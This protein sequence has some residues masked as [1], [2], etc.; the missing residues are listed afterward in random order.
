MKARHLVDAL[1]AESKPGLWA[2]MHDR[3]KKGLPKKR[4]GQK[5]YPTAAALKKSQK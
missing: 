5:G 2:N 1:V 3:R 4:P